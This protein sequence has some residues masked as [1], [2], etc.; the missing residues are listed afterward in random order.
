MK[1]NLKD[2]V[3]RAIESFALPVSAEEIPLTVQSAVKRTSAS[4][5][6]PV[7]KRPRM[8]ELMQE[9]SASVTVS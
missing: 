6:V 1:V 3:S 7:P 5:A 2:K 8:N 4:A 9:Q